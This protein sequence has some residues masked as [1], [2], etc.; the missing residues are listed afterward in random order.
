M[1]EVLGIHIY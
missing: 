1:R